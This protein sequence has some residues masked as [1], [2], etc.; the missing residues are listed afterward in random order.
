MTSLQQFHSDTEP[1]IS[2]S[3]LTDER[4]SMPRIM[5]RNI[6]AHAMEFAP[7]EVCGLIGGTDHNVWGLLA[8]CSNHSVDNLHNY[9][10]EPSHQWAIETQ[11]AERRA[12]VRAVYHS[13]VGKSAEPSL[14]DVTN[15]PG[16]L[17]IVIY[18]VR[19]DEIRVW[20]GNKP[21]SL[22]VHG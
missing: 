22:E 8:R 21:I 1:L 7:E 18:S 6:R 20:R 5:A 2:G 14:S 17:Y 16:D 11:F 12:K 13:H 10:I 3:L 9:R 4:V 15:T 19:D